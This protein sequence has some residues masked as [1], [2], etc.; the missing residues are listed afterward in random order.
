MDDIPFLSDWDFFHAK[1][2]DELNQNEELFD[3][4]INDKFKTHEVPFNESHWL[5][6]KEE[7]DKEE[8]FDQVIHEKIYSLQVPY[9][10]SHWLLMK[11]ELEKEE[12]IRTSIYFSKIVEA[13]CIFLILFTFLN[14]FPSFHTNSNYSVAINN[15]VQNA[16]VPKSINE[17]QLI[18]TSV[19]SSNEMIAPSDHSKKEVINKILDD[20]ISSRT[21]E[22]LQKSL[23]FIPVVQAKINVVNSKEL[24]NRFESKEFDKYVASVSSNTNDEEYRVEELTMLSIEEIE[25][26]KIK[27]SFYRQVTPASHKH[28]SPNE[29]FLSFNIA[30]TVNIVNS[31]FDY[32]NKTEPYSTDALGGEIGVNY[33][34]RKNNFEIETGL[35]FG[36]KSYAPRQV[37]EVIGSFLTSFRRLRLRQITY[38]VITIPISS[39]Y[40][41]ANGNVWSLYALA[42]TSVNGIANSDYLVE[43]NGRKISI[44]EVQ[45]NYRESNT[46]RKNYNPGILEGGDILDNVYFTFDFGIGMEYKTS[47]STLFYL[48]PTLRQHIG[49]AGVGPNNDK[50]HSLGLNMGI[51]KR[52]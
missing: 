26:L 2:S 28:G 44:Y 11:E 43:E 24:T 21:D 29:S 41:F 22:L 32:I 18:K 40:H 37:D 5:L 19:E 34:V 39:K 15:D 51:K 6:L 35:N 46:A 30:P 31:P 36:R 3:R 10:E 14:I 4:A 12:F 23:D 1:Y 8:I 45:T 49:L 27:R 16:S 25:P 13:A 7:L 20:K 52:L 9:N 38:D 50:V 47:E 48:A 17:K 33:S 42:G